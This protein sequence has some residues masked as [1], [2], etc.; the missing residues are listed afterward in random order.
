MSGLRHYV[1]PMFPG[2]EFQADVV[3]VGPREF[4]VTRAQRTYRE[5]NFTAFTDLVSRGAFQAEHIQRIN[6]SLGLESLA[7]SLE[8]AGLSVAVINCNVAP[9]T[10]EEIA[11][12]VVESKARVVG[13]SLIYRP[14][15]DFALRLLAALDGS[16]ARVVMG[17]AL[18]SY[19]PRELLSRLRR[20]DAVVFGEAE[21]TFRDY[22]LA[23]I[24]GG[25]PETLPG[26]AHRDRQTP[27]MNPAAE[28]LDLATIRSP[29]RNTLSYL[30]AMGWPTRI[31]SIYTSRGCLAKCTFCTGKDAYNVERPVSYRYR[32]PVDVVDEIQYLHEAFG[33]RFVYI[34]D[35]NFLGYGERSLARVR[36]F[37]EEL[38]DRRLTI[39]FA[40]ECRVDGIEPEI[41]A[42]L[43]QAGMR[44]VLLGVESGSDGVLQRWRKG[45]TVAQNRRAV[46]MCRAAGVTLEP[47]F[48]LFDAETSSAEF[49]DN[50][51]FIR[52]ARFA[53][54][55]FPNYLINRLSVYPGTEVEREW[56]E[57]GIIGPSPI[58][59]RRTSCPSDRTWLQQWRDGSIARDAPVAG[60]GEFVDRPADVLAYFQRLEYQCVDLRSEIAWRGLRV[61]IE[62]VEM[63]LESQFPGAIA[64]LSE[65]RGPQMTAAMRQE[66][67]DLIHRASRWRKGVG[68][69]VV[70]MMEA[71][72]AS[73]RFAAGVQQLRWLR[74]A[75][76]EARREHE[77]TTLGMAPEAFVQRVLEIRHQ[78]L[79]LQASVVVPT[80]VKWSRLKRTLHALSR[81]IVPDGVNWEV[82]LVCDGVEPPGGLAD[83]K[84][85]LPL[86][87]IRLPVARGRGAAR[88]AGVAAA[89][90]ETVIFLD[91]DVVVGENFVTSH[92]EAQAS[93]P[94]LCHGPILELPSLVYFDDL[95]TLAVVPELAGHRAVPRARK[96]AARLLSELADV[97]LCAARYGKPSVREI[98]GMQAFRRGH[99]RASWVA[100]AGANLAGPRKWFLAAPFDER[101]GVRWGLEDLALALRWSLDG[102]PLG[103]AEGALGLHLSHHRRNW[104]E[105]LRSNAVC[106]DFLPAHAA[107]VI[108]DYLQSQATLE[109]VQVA[110]AGTKTDADRPITELT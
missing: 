39:Q 13:I 105:N 77:Q 38:L 60:G 82:V 25:A 92:L 102:R 80:Q 110:L 67:R 21:E 104:R 68:P 26:I 61:G 98:D 97:R 18:A 74:R 53:E 73:Y 16:D 8:A 108:L 103:V 65:C 32:N 46:E 20:L 90:G 45:A 10:P 9:H 57:K 91:D 6:E 95:D 7:S 12:K 42:L 52:D 1:S 14:Q 5:K 99:S 85:N 70:R 71:A 23:V 101:P 106:L 88:N 31:A 3:L 29:A 24:G 15:V 64:I 4:E 75:L 36:R 78:L 51:Q 2:A 72:L 33:V 40:T 43:K 86:K 89:R 22:C 58:P 62:P 63:A 19:M 48:I 37:C 34:N 30:R 47:G 17:G 44:Q 55:P 28:P 27:V 56:T 109:D 87:V 54:I 94:T 83:F 84:A 11:R 107:A 50:L 59:A 96:F 93:R 76:T 81:Q 41:L 66:V 69:L 79:P 49:A 100:F 35:D